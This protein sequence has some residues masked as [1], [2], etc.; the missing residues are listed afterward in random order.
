VPPAAQR[1]AVRR[2]LEPTRLCLAPR[3]ENPV[4]RWLRFIPQ[5]PR[6]AE[7]GAILNGCAHACSV[8]ATNASR[9][10]SLSRVAATNASRLQSLSRVAIRL[11]Y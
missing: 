9:L 11:L 8:A 2:I 3:A 7:A 5:A 1:K 4:A 10:Q 6:I